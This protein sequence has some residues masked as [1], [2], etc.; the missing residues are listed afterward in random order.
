M[1]P[2]YVVRTPA[3]TGARLNSEARLMPKGGLSSKAIEA[4]QSLPDEL[5]PVF[6]ELMFDYK[7]AATRR[8]GYPWVSYIV[9][10]DLVR[11]GWRRAESDR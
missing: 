2:G 7:S 9:L 10:A 3:A 5:R 8:H 4:R 11:S 6:D 1:P